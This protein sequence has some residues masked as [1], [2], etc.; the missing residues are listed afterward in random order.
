MYL[1]PIF[2]LMGVLFFGLAGLC[3]GQ[4]DPRLIEQIKRKPV[5]QQ[6][7]LQTIDSFVA[8]QVRQVVTQHDFSQ[9]G[10]TR[11]VL[12][13]A[14]GSQAQYVQQF[15]QSCRRHIASALDQAADMPADRM[16][17]VILNL[18]IL[19]DS[20][21]YADLVELA[22]P[23]M[24]N[25]DPIIQYWAVRTVTGQVVADRIRKGNWPTAALVME[26]LKGLIKA[27]SMHQMSDLV[28]G[29]IAEM[30]VRTGQDKGSILLADMLQGR[31]DM[32]ASGQVYCWPQVDMT[33]LRHTGQILLG[34]PVDQ[35]LA[36]RFAQLF[37]YQIQF[38]ARSMHDKDPYIRQCLT[39]IV[40]DI[41]DKILTKAIDGYR[42]PLRT[43]IE[44]T[45]ATALMAAHD[46]IFGSSTG[47]G[48]LVNIWGF[49]YG[50]EPTGQVRRW[51]QALP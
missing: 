33:L 6:Q 48:I 32:F 47:S 28:W 51:P 11:A 5:L 23:Y 1:R 21:Q 16:F 17:M 2:S 13:A 8:G 49:D 25:Q 12:V 7:D 15:T 40:L 10:R 9:I 29:C 31:I 44:S 3:I 36:R 43:A 39:A 22:L 46:Q 37:S 42:R 14:R 20:L 26:Q 19:V 4:I 41:E 34:Q 50:L 27:R 18:L 38:L 45:D 24:T 35:A 30:A